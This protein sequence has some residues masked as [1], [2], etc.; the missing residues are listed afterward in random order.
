MEGGIIW[1][2]KS[3]T[4]WQLCRHKVDYRWVLEAINVFLQWLIPKFCITFIDGVD[5]ATWFYAHVVINQQKLSNRLNTTHTHTQLLY[6]SMDF[7]W[8][9]PGELV[10]EETFTH[11]HLSRSS[12]VPNLLHPSPTI[13]SILPLQFRCLTVF[14]HNLSPSFLWSTSW[15]GTST[16][17]SIHIFTQSLSSFRITCPYHRN[18]FHC[19]TEIMSSNPSLSLSTIYLEFCLYLEKAKKNLGEA[20][21]L[22]AALQDGCTAHCLTQQ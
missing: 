2:Q 16:S 19:S 20:S 18:L 7:V 22:L 13:H 4:P 8:D 9:N 11:S 1:L 14:F 12:I 15:P 6:G 10:P 3:K 17:Y 5:F 21:V